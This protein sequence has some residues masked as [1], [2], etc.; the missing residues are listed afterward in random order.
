LKCSTIVNGCTQ[1]LGIN[2][3]L[4]SR[5]VGLKLKYRTPCPRHLDNSAFKNSD[6]LKRL[7]SGDYDS[8]PIELSRF[9]K[10]KD[11]RGKKVFIQGLANR[12][13]A[14]IDAL[15]ADEL[16]LRLG[17]D[18]YQRIYTDLQITEARKIIAAEKVISIQERLNLL[19]QN[20]VAYHNQRDN[21]STGLSGDRKNNRKDNRIG[22]IMCNLTS[23]A[24]AL[25]VVGIS[26]PEPQ[27]FP[28]FEDYLEHLGETKIKN[29]NRESSGQDGWAGV[30]KLVGAQVNFLDAG[31]FGI[32]KRDWWKSTA[33]DALKSGKGI[34][35]SIHGHIVRLQ[36]VT[37]FG[38]V[39]DDPY[40][41]NIQLSAGSGGNANWGN[42]ADYGSLLNSRETRDGAIGNDNIWEWELVEKRSLHWL[43]EIS[44]A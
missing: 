16:D 40:G 18:G 33:L 11:K 35:F 14:E 21:A 24:M 9:N 12:R 10:G 44:R 8:I 41:G 4:R 3:L 26:N 25:E 22:D 13:E 30:A 39:I 34:I 43:A 20:K 28:Q 7:N 29:F 42:N 5:K 32:R 17:L 15:P 37:P 19:L 36:G 2:H 31:G 6:L 23:L 38:L 1:Q 27:N